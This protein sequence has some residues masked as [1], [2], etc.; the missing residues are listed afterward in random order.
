MKSIYSS[1]T[2]L[3]NTQWHTCTVL[4]VVTVRFV[5]KTCIKNTTQIKNMY[6]VVYVLFS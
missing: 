6:N 5:F 4:T 1:L 3:I 2:E